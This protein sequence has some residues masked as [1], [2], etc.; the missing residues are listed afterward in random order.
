VALKLSTTI[1]TSAL[2]FVSTFNAGTMKIMAGTRPG[3]T[4]GAETTILATVALQSPAFTVSNGV[5][6][7]NNPA[8]VNASAT[9]SATWFRMI[10]ANSNDRIDG[11]VTALGGGGDLELNTTTLVTG[12]SVDITG[13]TLT[14]PAG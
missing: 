6:T 5:A 11:L 7:L 4:T 10:G 1:R 2:A 3:D 9:G 12:V 13:G 14:M 8:A